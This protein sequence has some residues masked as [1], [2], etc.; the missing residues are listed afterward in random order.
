MSQNAISVSQ[1]FIFT[2]VALFWVTVIY[3]Y[4]KH[5]ERTPFADQ[6]PLRTDFTQEALSRPAELRFIT[7]IGLWLL[8]WFSPQVILIANVYFWL[9]SISLSF[10]NTVLPFVT[11]SAFID[12]LSEL[13]LKPISNNSFIF[14]LSYTLFET[15]TFIATL[16]LVYKLI[17]Q[18]FVIYAGAKQLSEIGK[19]AT[20]ER[21]HLRY[22]N[23]HKGFPPT[24]Q[25][26]KI[27]AQALDEV[28]ARAKEN[29]LPFVRP[30]YIYVTKDGKP[31]AFV[32]THSLFVSNFL[33]S[34]P[35][36]IN[37]IIAHEIGHLVCNHPYFTASV[38]SLPIIIFTDRVE[39]F[40]EK[41]PDDLFDRILSYGNKIIFWFIDVIANSTLR[42]MEY[43]ADAYAVALGYGQ[44]LTSSLMLFDMGNDNMSVSIAKRTHPYTQER[45][46]RIEHALEIDSPALYIDTQTALVNSPS[47]FQFPTVAGFVPKYGH[48]TTQQ[49]IDYA[50][51]LDK[52]FSSEQ[53]NKLFPKEPVYP[54]QK[55]YT[56]PDKVDYLKP[57]KIFWNNILIP[58]I[59]IVKYILIEISK[60][61]LIG[62]GNLFITI[63]DSSIPKWLK[64]FLYIL[65]LII[66]AAIFYI[67]TIPA[68]ILLGAIAILSFLVT[69]I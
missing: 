7:F 34:Q 26:A 9:F 3:G 62:L 48:L 69:R 66:I 1:L 50:S 61:I 29:N 35:Q 41:K 68:Y 46:I 55:E 30:Q 60:A 23:K 31:N 38:A 8:N 44:S 4:L 20:L 25:Q 57:V 21:T 11:Y 36:T 51:N 54:K 67:N 39:K 53:I 47:D 16:I 27:L 5:R 19:P 12:G 32:T 22:S 15:A 37:A 56:S 24:T 64:I 28:E 58:T 6:Y 14:S 45:V 40:I 43:D 42:Q 49:A 33:L 52:A 18:S 17:L 65:I 13:I 59:F 63:S 2:F 10:L